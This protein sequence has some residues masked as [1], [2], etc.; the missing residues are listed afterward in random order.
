MSE[1]FLIRAYRNY[2]S[3]A[4]ESCYSGTSTL[5]RS[6]PYLQSNVKRSQS[7]RSD[8]SGDFR[9]TLYICS[10]N[11]GWRSLNSN[12]SRTLYIRSSYC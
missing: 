5:S 8:N 2:N 1:N 6:H 10:S 9:A 7:T 12:M 3:T 11:S 4:S